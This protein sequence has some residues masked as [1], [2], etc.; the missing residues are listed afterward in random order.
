M[1]RLAGKKSPERNDCGYPGRFDHEDVAR[2]HGWGVEGE[3]PCD[4]PTGCPWYKEGRCPFHS[5]EG[6]LALVTIDVKQLYGEIAKLEKLP[7][8]VAQAKELA[9]KGQDVVL[10]GQGPVWLYLVVAHALHGLARSLSYD[11]PI[12]GKVVIFDHNPF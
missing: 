5:R 11:S 7:E 12:T 10:T 6:G 2:I 4:Y 8:Y 9:G 1:R 3:G